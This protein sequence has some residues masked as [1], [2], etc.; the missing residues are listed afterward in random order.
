MAQDFI[1]HATAMDFLSRYQK[2]KSEDRI[3]VKEALNNLANEMM[4]DAAISKFQ[5]SRVIRMLADLYV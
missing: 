5:V 4:A 1:E 2:N 3:N